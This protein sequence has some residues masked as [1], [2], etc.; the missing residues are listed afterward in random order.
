MMDTATPMKDPAPARLASVDSPA[1]R[2]AAPAPAPARGPFVPLLL[3]GATLAAWAGFQTLQLSAES[4]A[5][6]AALAQQEPLVQNSNKLR[7][8][9]D[10]MAAQTRTLADGGNPNARALVADMQRRGVTL[11][12]TPTA[13]APTR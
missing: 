8:S 1:H 6:Q 10:A 7:Q 12:A 11:A 3:I 9:L 4:T 2:P 13:P 5:M